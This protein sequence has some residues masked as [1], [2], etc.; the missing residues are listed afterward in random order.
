MASQFDSEMTAT[1]RTNRGI[2][3]ES[4]DK[5]DAIGSQAIS[6]EATG[7]VAGWEELSDSTPYESSRES[8]VL[9]G[10]W[11]REGHPHAAPQAR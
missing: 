7:R 11:R 3:R 1:R 6:D 5:S 8:R 2:R 4:L 10:G 9:S